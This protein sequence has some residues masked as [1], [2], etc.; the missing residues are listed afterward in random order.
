MA[1]SDLEKAQ[2]E[3]AKEASENSQKSLTAIKDL[4]TEDRKDNKLQAKDRVKLLKQQELIEKSNRT[5]SSDL[6]KNFS[7]LKDGFTS[8]VDGMI[9]ST[10]GPFSGIVSSFTTGFAKRSD[11]AADQVDAQNAAAESGRELAEKLGGVKETGEG[12][13]ASTKR[14]EKSLVTIADNVK[15]TNSDD[16]S[17]LG[18][19][20]ETGEVS[21]TQLK[22]IAEEIAELNGKTSPEDP[23]DKLKKAAALAAANGG[24]SKFLMPGGDPSR[25]DSGEKSPTDKGLISNL[26]TGAIFGAG[27]GAGSLTTVAGI[28][29]LGARFKLLSTKLTSG[30]LGKAFAAASLVVLGKDLFDIVDPATDDDIRTTVKNEDIL[31]V[32]LGFIGAGIGGFFTKSATGALI[33]MELGNAI[34]NAIGKAFDSPEVV[35]ELEKFENGL[36]SE[37]TKLV[38]EKLKVRELLRTSETDLDKKILQRQIDDIELRQKEVNDQLKLI[39]DETGAIAKQ[40]QKLKDASAAYV[41]NKNKLLALNQELAE[42]EKNGTESQK[43]R[44]RERKTILETLDKNL[45]D[46]FLLQKEE[47]RKV[48]ITIVPELVKI[49]TRLIDQLRTDAAQGGFIGNLL[50]A[51]GLFGTAFEGQEKINYLK[52][53]AEEERDKLKENLRQSE[54]MLKEEKE[55]PEKDRTGMTQIK[56]LNSQIER[57][58]KRIEEKEA[59]IKD[60]PLRSNSKDLSYINAISDFFKNLMNPDGK[61]EGGF[62]V[63]KPTYLPNSGVVV[64]E[65]GTYTGGANRG[66]IADGGPEAIIPL[67]STRAGAFINPMAQSIA[68]QVMNRLQMERMSGDVGGMEGASI[69]TGNDMSSNQVSNNN[70]VIN[71]PSPIGQTLPDEGRD[72]VSKVA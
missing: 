69:V 59:E 46:N 2:R 48:T 56:F 47:L 15:P 34:G 10:F 3:A 25:D 54:V 43:G 18:G 37:K 64:G 5:L 44:L 71:N 28:K 55:K 26:L 19:V 14:M 67:N 42:A 23:D 68:G 60:I 62:I 72:F 61:A 41:K 22:I 1:D 27:T 40:K 12:Q 65:H 57:L 11:E 53:E 16:A 35:D 45:A 49:Q 20:K 32:M 6:G 31:G 36:L 7:D 29:A 66:G 52:T 21:V 9:S 58:E 39:T 51:F 70:T 63:N 33:G 50:T 38:D 30:I 17:K 13:L 8:T 4:L 24:T